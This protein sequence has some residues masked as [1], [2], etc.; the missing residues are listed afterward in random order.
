M[1]ELDAIVFAGLDD[2]R[3]IAGMSREL[4]EPGLVWAWTPARVQ[5]MIANRDAAVIVV[6]RAGRIAAFAMMDFGEDSAHLSLLAVAPAHR[7][8]GL[9]RQLIDWLVH[10]AM[11]AGI[12]T[13]NLELRAGNGEALAFYRALG[14][15]ECGVEPGYY[16]GRE[17]ALRMS[18]RLGRRT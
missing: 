8:R 13:I 4:V 16:Q 9:G 10:S 17:A 6:R 11:T 3:E 5:H 15:E 2:A 1:P 14:F 18:R 12:F 7:R